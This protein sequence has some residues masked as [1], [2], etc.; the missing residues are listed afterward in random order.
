MITFKEKTYACPMEMTIDLIGGKWKALLLW[1]LSLGTRRFHEL[2]KQFP[3]V[4]QKMLTQQLRGL[5][6]NGLVSR[7]V[8]AEVPPKVEYTLTDFG[9]TLMPVLIAMNQ[10]GKEYLGGREV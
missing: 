7:K 1:N 4:T 5:E 8:Y 10:W 6:N 3:G 9:M 2:K